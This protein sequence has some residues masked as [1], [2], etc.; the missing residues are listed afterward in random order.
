MTIGQQLRAFLAREIPVSMLWP[1][2]LTQVSSRVI[3]YNS[4]GVKYLDQCTN[5]TRDSLARNALHSKSAVVPGSD[6][7]F[8]FIIIL[9]PEDLQLPAHTSHR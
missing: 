6:T 4:P 9:V 3:F 5:D 1:C 7:S 8:L 2:V